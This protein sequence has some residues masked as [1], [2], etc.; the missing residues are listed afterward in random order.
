MVTG[1]VA[2]GNT[3]PPSQHQWRTL[4]PRFSA[5]GPALTTTIG[6]TSGCPKVCSLTGSGG[7]NKVDGSRFDSPYDEGTNGEFAHAKNECRKCNDCR[8]LMRS[9]Q[10]GSC[11]HL[12]HGVAFLRR[13]QAQGSSSGLSHYGLVC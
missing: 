12:A 9:D 11:S 8:Q 1:W 5:R 13:A 4:V 10:T 6:G 2:S 7:V 3:T